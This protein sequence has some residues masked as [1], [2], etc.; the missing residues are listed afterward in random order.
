MQ[1]QLVEYDTIDFDRN[2][3]LMGTGYDFAEKYH[4]HGGRF[5]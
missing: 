1:Q 5:Q 3:G 4:V 2:G